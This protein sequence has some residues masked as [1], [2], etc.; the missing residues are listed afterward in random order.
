MQEKGANS[1]FTMFPFNFS[2]QC[3]KVNKMDDE[4]N[5]ESDPVSESETEA[6]DSEMEI[7]NEIEEPQ[8]T[9]VSEVSIF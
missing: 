4:D 5:L 1:T 3:K 9:A 2:F 8:L 6:S 7:D